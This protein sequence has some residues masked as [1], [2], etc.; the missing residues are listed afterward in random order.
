MFVYYTFQMLE[1]GPSLACWVV[2]LLWVKS[3]R[4]SGKRFF[5]AAI[6]RRASCATRTRLDSQIEMYV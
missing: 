5:L 6:A 1:G 4:G 2:W 3:C